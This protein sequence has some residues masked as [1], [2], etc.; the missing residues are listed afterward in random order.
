MLS[1]QTA[2]IFEMLLSPAVIMAEIA[3]CSAQKPMPLPMSIHTPKYKLPLELSK[4]HATSPAWPR[5]NSRGLRT[6][7]A[8][9]I[10]SRFV[11]SFMIFYHCEEK[12]PTVCV[13]RMS[14]I[15]T[16]Q[17]RILRMIESRE[18]VWGESVLGCPAAGMGQ[19]QARLSP[20]RY[21]DTRRTLIWDWHARP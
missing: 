1:P 19:S 12:C 7:F 17:T 8:F 11:S 20:L 18:R 5:N 4:A 9:S 3:L 14:L 10:I 21:L 16:W 13:I 2:T 6:D 15:G